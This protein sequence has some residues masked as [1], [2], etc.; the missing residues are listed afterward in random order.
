MRK[1]VAILDVLIDKVDQELALE[2]IISCLEQ[3]QQQLIVT[4]NSEMIVQAQQ[5]VKLKEIINCADLALP[6]GAGVVLASKILGNP[7]PERVAGID[8]V[9]QL[10][11]IANQTNYSFYFL[12]G[13]PK[14]AQQAKN[15][16]L[17][18]YPHLKI[19]V[20]HGYLTR[21]LEEQVINDIIIRSPDILLVGMGV[22]LQEKWLA[23]YLVEFEG[24]IGIGVGGTFDILAGTKKRA[25]GWMQKFNLEWL[26][27]VIQEPQRIHR[28][29]QLPQFMQQVLWQRYKNQ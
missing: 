21:V 12:G 20:H 7:I 29:I 28:V 15:R 17:E 8:L 10:F 22:P 13:A 14:I 18:Q 19:S 27:R 23:K 24:T 25:P 6:D 11:K 16:V 5:D 9:Q 2:K 3:G 1:R 26:Y 4:P